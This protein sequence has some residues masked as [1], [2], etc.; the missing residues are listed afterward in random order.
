MIF[1]LSV[2]GEK[3]D[4]N[5]NFFYIFGGMYNFEKVGWVGIETFP[6]RFALATVTNKVCLTITLAGRKS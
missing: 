3:H 1:L 5:T 6:Q 2:L 4:K